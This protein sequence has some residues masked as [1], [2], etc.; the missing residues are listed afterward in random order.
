MAG[1]GIVPTNQT[2][3][4][5]DTP[6]RTLSL[7]WKGVSWEQMGLDDCMVKKLNTTLVTL[8]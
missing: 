2:S 1:A 5:G 7:G 8:V 6:I 4:P 3:K